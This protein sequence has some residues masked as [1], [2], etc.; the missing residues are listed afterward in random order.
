MSASSEFSPRLDLV[1]YISHQI[2]ARRRKRAI[3][4]GRF[5]K[6][7]Q[8]AYQKQRR[9]SSGRPSNDAAAALFYRAAIGGKLF[10]AT[11]D[12]PIAC[13]HTAQ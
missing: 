3:L 5:R 9:P 6:V 11:S 8:W 13:D 2:E 4:L 12:P 7:V 10:V 1:A